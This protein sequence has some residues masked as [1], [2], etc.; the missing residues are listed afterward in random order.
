MKKKVKIIIITVM[1][2]VVLILI[3]GCEALD[4]FISTEDNKNNNAA[5]DNNRQTGD[6]ALIENPDAKAEIGYYAPDF[7]VKLLSGDAVKLSDFRGKVVFINFWATWCEPCV[8]E[9]PDMQELF[10]MFPDDLVVL[11]VNRSEKKDKVENFIAQN[12][13]TF[14]IGLDEN[15]EIQEKY[16]TQG[17]PYTI[18]INPEGLITEI[19]LGLGNITIFEEYV[20]EALVK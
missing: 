16:P 17:I 1:I 14:N 18:I 19:R 5:A 4:N 7:N 3:S 9:M 6:D 2:S 11:A 8:S 20:R 12:G 15:G 10:E 13:Y